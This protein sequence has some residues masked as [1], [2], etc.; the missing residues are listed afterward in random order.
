MPVKRILLYSYEKINSN[1]LFFLN[2]IS[3]YVDKIIFINSK[4]IDEICTEV[5][6]SIENAIKENNCYEEYIIANDLFYG[7]FSNLKDVFTKMSLYTV[8]SIDPRFYKYKSFVVFSRNSISSND[9]KVNYLSSNIIDIDTNIIDLNIPFLHKS[10]FHKEEYSF[11]SEKLRRVY[12]YLSNNSDFDFDII[13]EDL[14]NSKNCKNVNSIF[15][16]NYVIPSL[17]AENAKYLSKKIA[18]IVYL[19][20]EELIGYI[21]SYVKNIPE[22]TDIYIVTTKEDIIKKVD[23]ALCNISNYIEYRMQVNRGRDNVA[24]LVT[25][26]DLFEKYD[27]I[28]FV[29]SKQSKQNKITSKEFRNH[30]FNSLLYNKQYV[31]NLLNKFEE[32]RYLGLLIPYPPEFEPYSTIGN[33][34]LNNYENAQ[35]I[36]RLR[37]GKNINLQKNDVICAFGNM[38]WIKTQACKSLLEMNFK[39]D[40]FPNEPLTQNDGLLTHSIERIIPSLVKQD[41]FY[42]SYAIPDIEASI[43]I[44][45]LMDSI[46]KLKRS[47]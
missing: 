5:Y 47:M 13:I 16:M 37:L 33:E 36:V 34:W 10:Y 44:N 45:T 30:C 4:P 42:T 38:F 3:E 43:Y 29:H 25:C 15:S 40:D 14:I 22:S 39:I 24:L 8:W 20:A 28:G 27:Y 32:N 11:F 21:S 41:G 31:N 17:Y 9:D 2:K 26:R 19:Y 1:V 18:L 12:D 7:P 46:K 23:L 35:N 6:S